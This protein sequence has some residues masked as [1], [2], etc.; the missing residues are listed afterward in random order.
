MKVVSVMPCTAKKFEINRHEMMNDGVP[1]VDA[2]LTTRE[3][4]RM[5]REA[6][7]DF[8]RPARF[9]NLKIRWACPPARP[10]SSASPAA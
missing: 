6:G 10:I 5:I 7:I 8:L 9:R 4:G 3:L 1:N 2:V